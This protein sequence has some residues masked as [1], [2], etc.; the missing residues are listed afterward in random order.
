MLTFSIISPVEGSVAPAPIG[1]N[2]APMGG[3]IAPIEEIAVGDE[4]PVILPSVLLAFQKAQAER[5][6]HFRMIRDTRRACINSRKVPD[7]LA[8][9]SLKLRTARQI[10]RRAE[11]EAGRDRDPRRVGTK[12]HVMFDSSATTYAEA[13]IFFSPPRRTARRIDTGS[14]LVSVPVEPRRSARI[15]NLNI[16]AIEAL[17][18]RA[19]ANS[20]H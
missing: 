3:P 5:K 2:E 13:P 19:L 8:C 10:E 6:E 11:I 7:P 15:R 9:L 1:E 14:H 17:A 16:K 4:D 18:A 20:Q 12:H